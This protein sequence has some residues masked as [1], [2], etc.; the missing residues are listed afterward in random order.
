MS[1]YTTEVRYICENYAGLTSSVDGGKIGD[2]IEK[3]REKVFDFD[4]PIYD[5]SYRSVLES[6][7]LKRYYTRE[8]GFETVGLWKHFLDMRLNEIMPFYNQMYKSALLEFNPFYD[9]DITTDSKRGIQHDE[10]STKDSNVTSK[11]SSETNTTENSNRNTSYSNATSGKEVS[12]SSGKRTDNLG[13]TNNTTVTSQNSGESTT[14]D[15]VTD[16]YS[17]TPQNGLTDVVTGTYLTNA[18]I[19]NDLNNVSRSDNGTTTTKGIT[20][21]TGNVVTEGSETSDRSGSDSGSSQTTNGTNGNENRTAS[22]NTVT[23]E[24]GTRKFTNTDEYLEHVRGKRGGDSYA[25]LL[26]EYRKTFLNIDVM[27]IEELGD[28]FMNVW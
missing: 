10:T 13:H 14:T 7:I 26:Q 24:D 8:I 12:S 3:S 6:K 15:Q 25:K 5:E 1:K 11:D 9:V 20:S 22:G 27:I 17:D 18:R 19:T 2:V 16:K 23:D 21:D 4:F 28:L